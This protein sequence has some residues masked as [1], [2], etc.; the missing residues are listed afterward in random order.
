MLD[1]LTYYSYGY[2]KP[3]FTYLGGTTLQGRS[4]VMASLVATKKSPW[5]YILWIPGLVN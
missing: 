1:I 4:L 3:T 5:L 2:H